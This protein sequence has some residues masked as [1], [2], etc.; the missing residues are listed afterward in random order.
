[1]ASRS[2]RHATDS[3]SCLCVCHCVCVCFTCL[4]NRFRILHHLDHAHVVTGGYAAVRDE[5]KVETTVLPELVVIA[6]ATENT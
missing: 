1:M 5:V 2:N 3:A 4:G 6:T